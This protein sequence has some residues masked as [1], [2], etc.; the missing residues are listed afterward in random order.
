MLVFP[1]FWQGLVTFRHLTTAPHL[2]YE[3]VVLNS[4][5]NLYQCFTNLWH[6]GTPFFPELKMVDLHWPNECLT[7]SSPSAPGSCVPARVS[8]CSGLADETQA[9]VVAHCVLHL[10][11]NDGCKGAVG[12]SWGDSGPLEVELPLGV[13]SCLLRDLGKLYLPG[14]CSTLGM[15]ILFFFYNQRLIWIWIM[16]KYIF[17]R[18]D[19][20]E[21]DMLSWKNLASSFLACCLAGQCWCLKS[22]TRSC[23]TGC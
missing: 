4:F 17:S 5:F 13:P 7:T 8:G 20:W 11:G 15:V 19:A 6:L 12:H 18:K 10:L 3:L 22:T 1:S 16:H 2:T 9:V 14:R 23:Q 21:E